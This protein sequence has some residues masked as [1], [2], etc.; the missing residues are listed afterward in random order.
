MRVGLRGR[1]EEERVEGLAGDSGADR[2]IGRQ[3]RGREEAGL[4]TSWHDRRRQT[5]LGQVLCDLSSAATRPDRGLVGGA[6]GVLYESVERPSVGHL[7][8]GDVG[9]V[10]GVQL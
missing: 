8:V 7:E 10:I 1:D 6:L 4:Q 2:G 3:E 9:M 5:P